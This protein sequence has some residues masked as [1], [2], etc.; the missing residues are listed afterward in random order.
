MDLKSQT[1]QRNAYI[2]LYRLDTIFSLLKPSEKQ[3]LRHIK[4]VIELNELNTS[5]SSSCNSLF[6]LL[7][8]LLIKP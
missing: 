6:I 3:F 7:C 8:L 1:D 2:L 5:D 4:W